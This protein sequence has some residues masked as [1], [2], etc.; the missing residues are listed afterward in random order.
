[1]FGLFC[2]E[3]QC[4]FEY[5]C[6][7]CLVDMCTSFSRLYICEWSGWV[8]G[9]AH[10]L[11]YCEKVC[12]IPRERYSGELFLL[13]MCGV[14]TNPSLFHI[15]LLLDILRLKNF[16]PPD[17]SEWYL[18][19]VLLFISLIIKE[20]FPIHNGH[21]SCLIYEMSLCLFWLWIFCAFLGGL[22]FLVDVEAISW[23]LRLC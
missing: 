9:C 16:C 15:L 19:V 12:C 2:F 4:C 17:G 7:G 18:I 5:S 13:A 11:C 14:F 10:V 20:H 3:E 22:S 6:P 8:V 1:M 21:S 23:I